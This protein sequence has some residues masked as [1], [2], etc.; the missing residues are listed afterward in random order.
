MYFILISQ[1]IPTTIPCTYQIYLLKFLYFSLSSWTQHAVIFVG[2]SNSINQYVG[3]DDQVTAE[4]V[5]KWLHLSGQ[6]ITWLAF[7][8][9]CYDRYQIKSRLHGKLLEWI[10]YLSSITPVHTQVT[11]SRPDAEQR[12]LW[13]NSSRLIWLLATCHTSTLSR[14]TC[15]G[16]HI[17]HKP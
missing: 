1:S 2:C 4:Q 17:C 8:R 9:T 6:Y 16:K 5:Q 15:H 10:P 7:R 13:A 11:C 14:R 12:Q 3:R